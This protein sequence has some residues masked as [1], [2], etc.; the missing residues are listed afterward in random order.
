[1][2]FGNNVQD[3]RQLF[4]TSW[5]KYR[6]GQPLTGLEQQLVNVI[7]DHP[8]YHGMFEK[9]DAQNEQAWFPEMGETNPFLHLGL[10]LAIRD[11]VATNSPQGFTKLFQQ[12]LVQYQDK[13]LVE[14]KIM[15]CLAESL[16][17]A[18]R[19]GQAPDETLYV[20]AVS[21]LLTKP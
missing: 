9:N 2:L 14:H 5:Q 18:Q 15:E 10:H 21:R 16:W 7:I 6:L 13:L 19:N 3:T 4:Y 12:L 8:E 17:Q 20:N 1:M 11:Q